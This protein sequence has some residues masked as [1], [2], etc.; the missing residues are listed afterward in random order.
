LP[1][2]KKAF[3]VAIA[4]SVSVDSAAALLAFFLSL[5]LIKA[6][7]INMIITLFISKKI[8]RQVGWGRQVGWRR[9]DSAAP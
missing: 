1:L 8:V 2:Y 4:T 7:K 6:I 3:K 9:G 5:Q